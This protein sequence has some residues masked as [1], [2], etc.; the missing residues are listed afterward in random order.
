M[1]GYARV[2][3]LM[4]QDEFAILRRFKRLNMQNL[5]YL[6]A[7][8]THL[9]CELSD[10]V[11]RDLRNVEREYYTKDWWSLSQSDEEEDLEQWEKFQELRVKLEAYNE[12][13]LKQSYLVKLSKPRRYDLDFLRSWFERP[14]MG[15]FPLLGIDKASWEAQ[16]EDDLVALKPRATSDP[17]SRWFC[18][19]IVPS[20][21][22]VLGEKFKE[23][24]REAIGTGIY[25]YA[26]SS[27]ISTVQILTTVVASLLP[28]CSVVTLYI[29]ESNNMRL[30]MIVVFSACFSLALATMTNA[31]TVEVFAATAA[32][33]AVNVVFLTNNPPCG[34]EL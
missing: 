10:L 12:S 11:D 3:H 30:G 16:Y 32:F 6:Q 29:T 7:E 34:T 22:H 31:R 21:H 25:N 13:L 5:L 4:S 15:N 1:E 33:A 23:P 28:L 8:I 2:A 19:R 24:V 18:E 20:F 26:E 17:F 27:L 9:E 14:G